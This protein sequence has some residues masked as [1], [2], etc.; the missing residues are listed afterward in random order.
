MAISPK[1]RNIS[2]LQI[3]AKLQREIFLYSIKQLLAGIQLHV[4]VRRSRG[5][6]LQLGNISVTNLF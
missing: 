3:P 4:K 5:S 2:R 1:C 6:D